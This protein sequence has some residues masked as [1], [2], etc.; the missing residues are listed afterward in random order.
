VSNDRIREARAR[1]P[2]IFIYCDDPSHPGRRV[3]VTNYVLTPGGTW[4]EEPASRASTGHVG[5]GHHLIGD[6]PAPTGWALD[7]DVSNA[8]VRDHHELICRKCKHRPVRLRPET[9][10]V[11]LNGWHAAGVSQ[12]ALSMFAASMGRESGN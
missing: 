10:D 4:T 1:A 5:A 2:R 12:V 9:L 11:V 6:T 8:E 7:P 3:A